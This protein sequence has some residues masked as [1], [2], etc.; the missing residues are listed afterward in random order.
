MKKTVPMLLLL[1]TILA[2]K[3]QPKK[4]QM[5]EPNP[6][7]KEQVTADW[8]YLFD[9]SSTEGWRGYNAD[10]LPPGWIIKDSILTFD[11]ERKTEAEY[12]GGKDIIYGLE[13][14]ENFEFS[15][16]W[17]IPEGGNSGIFYH[18]KEGYDGP[19][20][21]SPEY[22]LI[23]DENY[24]RLHDVT[25]YNLS[26]GNTNNPSELQPSQKTASDYAMY[27]ADPDKKI[28]HP[29]GEWNTSRIVFTPTKAEYWLNGQ[30][31]VS[32][33]PWSDDWQRKKNEGKWKNTPDYGKY[34]TGFIGLQDHD[35]P[36]W[37]RNI[38]IRKL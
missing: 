23:D 31:V 16:E 28:L 18:L 13:E 3:D 33:V 17:K 22:Q 21:V 24:A 29:A 27:P 36:L 2:C 35:S 12:T 1:L 15:L 20:D 7:T 32:F 5:E 14:F 38:K 8:K 30:L 6:E 34:K 19:P 11:T 25:A 10:S 26:L 9:G 37:F 4:E